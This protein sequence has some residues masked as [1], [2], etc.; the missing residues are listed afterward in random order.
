MCGV[1]LFTPSS[2]W[3]YRPEK[4]SM[5]LIQNAS[6][7]MLS[8]ILPVVLSNGLLRQVFRAWGQ[9]SNMKNTLTLKNGFSNMTMAIA[10]PVFCL[11][12]STSCVPVHAQDSES[13]VGTLRIITHVVNDNGGTKEA[14][15][16]SNCIDTSSG[17]SSSLQCSSGDE[18]GNSQNSFD[19]GNYKVTS[20]SNYQLDGYAV[21][22]SSDC[23]GVIGNGQTKVCTVTYDDIAHP[24]VAAN[25]SPPV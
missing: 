24:L 17:D 22:Y 16:F 12:V 5:A 19:A 15:D 25:N 7:G 14:S 13:P 2:F 21:S 8:M 18:Q 23:S 20:D 6:K 3:I 11:L 1:S 9:D 4:I 10:I